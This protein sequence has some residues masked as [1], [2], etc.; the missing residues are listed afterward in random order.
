MSQRRPW[1]RGQT[2]LVV[3]VVVL[4]RSFTVWV[5]VQPPA[6]LHLIMGAVSLPWPCT[7][8]QGPK[9]ST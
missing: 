7:C 2:L 1:T 6:S 9:K 4:A 5:S 8:V 3:V